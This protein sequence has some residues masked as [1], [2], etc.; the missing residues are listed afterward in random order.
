MVAGILTNGENAAHNDRTIG[1][2]VQGDVVLDRQDAAAGKQ[3]VPG[4]A[5][6]RKIDKR[7][8]SI[9]EPG[10]IGAALFNAPMLLGIR[11]DITKI[12]TG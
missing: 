5:A 7:P 12:L 2:V 11:E 10:A 4:R 3:V 1:D 6:F 9:L 8:H